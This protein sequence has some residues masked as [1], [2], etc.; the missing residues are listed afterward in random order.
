MGLKPKLKP[1]RHHPITVEPAGGRVRVRFRGR[2][3]ASTERALVLTEATYPPVLYIPKRDVATD[4]LE[5]SSHETY[6]PYKG[7]ASYY[8]LRHADR[9]AE[10]AVWTY[11]SPYDAVAPIAGHV[12]FYPDQVEIEHD[13]A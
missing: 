2:E 8:S 13:A 9:V 11:E 7:E 12:A 10:Y 4:A 3:I 5:P 1:G 6:C